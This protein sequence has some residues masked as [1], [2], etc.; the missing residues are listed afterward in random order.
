MY[1]FI[2][3][4]I[5]NKKINIHSKLGKNIIK[6]YLNFIIGGAD[7]PTEAYT[8]NPDLLE[9]IFNQR[10]KNIT[11]IH[12][13]VGLD[14]FKL[15]TPNGTKRILLLSD[16]HEPLVEKILPDSNNAILF[17]EFIIYLIQT[18]ALAPVCVDFYLENTLTREQGQPLKGRPFDGGGMYRS[19][20]QIP[21]TDLSTIYVLRSIFD[22]CSQRIVNDSC[23]INELRGLSQYNVPTKT[24]LDNLRLHNIDLRQNSTEDYDLMPS[25]L[26]DTGYSQYFYERF[27]QYVLDRP[28]RPTRQQ[29]EEMC[30]NDPNCDD[31]LISAH[32]NKIDKVK[33]KINKKQAKIFD[34]KIFDIDINL[35]TKFVYDFYTGMS[36]N[37]SVT[38]TSITLNASLVDIYTILRIFKNFEMNTELKR[39]RGP[40]KC[41]GIANQDNIIVFAG[42]L[43]T[44]CYKYVLERLPGCSFIYGQNSKLKKK[45]SN[46]KHSKILEIDKKQG[47]NNF[48][49]LMVDFCEDLSNHRIDFQ[50]LDNTSIRRAVHRY[51]YSPQSCPPINKWIVSEVTDMSYLFD[52][53]SNFNGNISNWDTGK[54]TDMSYMFRRAI[55]FNQPLYFNTG[56]VTNMESMFQ[57]AI[58]F[59]QP[60]DF[61]TINV[62]NMSFMFYE[63]KSF[64][65]SL[66]FSNTQ[67]VR[68]MSSMFRGATAFNQPL[69][70]NTRSV[71]NMN[72]MFE[73]T[74][75]FDKPLNFDTGKVTDM[76]S[77]FEDALVFNQPLSWNTEN[78]RNMSSMFKG[79]WT[80][81]G[82]ITKWNTENVTNMSSMF[83][84]TYNFDQPLNFN[85]E[86]VTDMESMFQDALVFN[87]PLSWNTRNVQNMSSMFKDA[88]NFNQSL[89]WDTGNTT[90]FTDMDLIFENSL[91]R[92]IT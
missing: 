67:Y 60:L 49:E 25:F 3:N 47:F 14:Y 52:D 17:D 9:Y 44:E 78:V 79:A 91:G 30:V 36:T 73:D 21:M 86:K 89:E 32:I 53:F 12:G 85:T 87:Q 4:P 37:I 46:G 66:N 55:T 90:D 54:V 27:L 29:L 35:I 15:D 65:E 69:N 82:N 45:T 5:D 51:K 92:L 18:L 26:T 62:N 34:N 24:K 40:S 56:K 74:Y 2:K 71:T 83:E 13:L 6:K 84:D 50:N 33:Q 57:G 19:S 20:Y 77:M 23:T 10:S 76:S 1:K 8:N 39:G 31:S 63:A 80:F 72:S 16:E 11:E 38:P 75:N 70:F 41:K 58:G 43:H 7:V 88:M 59:N 28:E 64:N 22:D 81:D 42:Y 48:N 61:N 68:N